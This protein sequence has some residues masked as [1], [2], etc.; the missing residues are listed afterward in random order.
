MSDTPRARAEREML[1][2]SIDEVLPRVGDQAT[3]DR[4]VALRDGTTS[5]RDYV[6]GLTEGSAELAA[7]QSVARELMNQPD[8]Q[9]TAVIHAVEERVD[10][11]AREQQA[12]PGPTSTGRD[13]DD[14]DD[15]RFLVDAW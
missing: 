1:R 13:D 3:R 10:A 9:H 8:D 2:R 6:A 4:L 7:M 14:P 15:R 5:V 12:Q 11:V